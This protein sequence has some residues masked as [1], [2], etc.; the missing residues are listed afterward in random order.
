MDLIEVNRVL[1][2]APRFQRLRAE[3]NFENGRPLSVE[4]TQISLETDAKT[5]NMAN[6]KIITGIRVKNV[7]A[8]FE[9]VAS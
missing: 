2:A 9:F 4:N 3:K 8:G 7:V 6:K 5:L 1:V